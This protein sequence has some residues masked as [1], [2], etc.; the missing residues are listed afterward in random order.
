MEEYVRTGPATPG[1]PGLLMRAETGEPCALGASF[2]RIEMHDIAFAPSI[3]AF[4]HHF[5]SLRDDR[6]M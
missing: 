3:E 5:E 2:C 6:D 4:Q 1:T